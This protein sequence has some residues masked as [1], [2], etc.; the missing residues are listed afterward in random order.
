VER[1][2]PRWTR[3]FALAAVATAALSGT[4]V[5]LAPS[6]SNGADAIPSPEDQAAAEQHLDRAVAAYDAGR[7]EEALTEFEA[8]DRLYPRPR[9]RFNVAAS[10]RALGRNVEALEAYERFLEDP[11]GD[12][13]DRQDAEDAI[14]ELAARVGALEVSAE[15]G[16]EV[17]VDGRSHGAAP[18]ARAVRLAP[19]S[20]QVAVDKKGYLPFR[21]AVALEAGQTARLEV[22][23]APAP[24]TP[25][26]LVGGDTPPAPEGKRP[27]YKS[28]WFWTGAALVAAG[29]AATVWALWPKGCS[30]D[31][32]GCYV[33]K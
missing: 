1:N 7:F 16:A 6:P 33:I 10:Y 2:S 9:L 23:L 25:G 13:G 21:K 11:T 24:A 4:V 8:A 20:H 12:P 5:V 15:P 17:T 26:P 18:L 28:P 3:G 14:V 29:A 27:F 22:V 31:L 19:G 30:T 32:G